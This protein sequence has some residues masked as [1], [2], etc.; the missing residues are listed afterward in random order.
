MRRSRRRGKLRAESGVIRAKVYSR[1]A[2]L[3]GPHSGAVRAFDSQC[4]LFGRCS[5]G[6]LA[7]L[8]R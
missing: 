8:G 3:L 6:I 5:L 4:M 2:T 7:H 1:L